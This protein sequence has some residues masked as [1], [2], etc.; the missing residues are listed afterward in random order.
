MDENKAANTAAATVGEDEDLMDEKEDADTDAT[1]VGEEE[2]LCS[3]P[4]DEVRASADL[5]Q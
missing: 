3:A 2:D 4:F 5:D 1:T